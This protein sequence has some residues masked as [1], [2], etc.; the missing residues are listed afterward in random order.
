MSNNEHSPIVNDWVCTAPGTAVSSSQNTSLA[1]LV[2]SLNLSIIVGNPAS[3]LINQVTNDSRNTQ[4][5]SL[6]VAL[7]GSLVT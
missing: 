6:F 4:P 2:E 7:I 3:C 5:G 1:N